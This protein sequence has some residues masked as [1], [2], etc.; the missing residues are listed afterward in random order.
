M[1]VVEV[2]VVDYWNVFLLKLQ[3]CLVALID[4]GGQLREGLFQ[5]RRLIGKRDRWWMIALA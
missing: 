5:F 3:K 2:V 1:V 4:K